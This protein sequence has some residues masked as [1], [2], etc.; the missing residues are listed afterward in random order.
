LT[1]LF[2]TD[3]QAAPPAQTPETTPS[4]SG[5]KALWA[6]NCLPCHGPTG[7]GDGPTAQ[8]IPN[9]V[10]NL[11]DP[12]VY[13]NRTPAEHFD[14]IKNGRI[15]KLM[16]PWGNRFSDAQIWDLVAYT[17]SLHTSPATLAASATLY[18]KQCAGCHG[19]AGVPV[20]LATSSISFADLPA[21]TQRSLA[22]LQ[23]GYHASLAHADLSLSTDELWLVLDHVRALSYLLPRRD[24]VLSGQIV[25]ATANQPQGDLPVTLYAFESEANVITSTSQADSQGKYTFS[26][27]ATDPET[28]Y[29]VESYY[30]EVSYLTDP[31]TFAEDSRQTTVDLNVYETTTRPDGV[32]LSRLN[33][34]VSPRPDGLQVLQIFVLSNSGDKTYIGQNGQTF[35]FKLP[36]SA[37]NIQF[38]ND[39]G[40]RF[41]RT[42]DGYTTAEPIIPGAEGLVI[43]A[44]YDLPA[45]GDSLTVEL[46]IPAAIETINLLLEV[47]AEAVSLDSPQLQFIEFRDL[48]NSR[49]AAY[50]GGAF[51]AGDILSLIFSGL[52]SVEAQPSLP[53]GAVAAPPSIIDQDTLRWLI[54]GLSGLA[55]ALTV[56]LYAFRGSPQSA[57]AS[58]AESSAR[59]HKLLL[60]LARLDEA[61]AA[62]EIEEPLYRQARAGYKTELVRL[63]RSEGDERDGEKGWLIGNY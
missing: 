17:W 47:Q 44:S 58:Q 46:P 10:G 27:L 35:A 11:L 13:R 28:L 24:G 43:A 36:A 57:S 18:D 38:Q 23:A 2:L 51:A 14:V 3:S 8:S 5:G 25:N 37:T 60:L 40:H 19:L 31:Q 63:M 20:E 56:G 55:I 54:L 29:V 30:D 62:G 45:E 32:Q 33:Q 61:V 22:D 52:D 9:P 50:S 59:Q 21:M 7:R 6:E 34:I 16:P 1:G 12:E 39:F 48:Q 15:E 42:G 26:N 41:S 53:P 4:V 49:F